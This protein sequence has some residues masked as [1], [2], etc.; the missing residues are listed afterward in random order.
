MRMSVK[1]MRSTCRLAKAAGLL[2]RTFAEKRVAVF[3]GPAA[4]AALVIFYLF[5][6][7]TA[8]DGRKAPANAA[9]FLRLVLTVEGTPSDFSKSVRCLTEQKPI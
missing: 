4:Q 2:E 9:G 3:L 6:C 5:D 7:S 8:R 1:T